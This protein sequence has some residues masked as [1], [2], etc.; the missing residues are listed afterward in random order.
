MS[1]SVVLEVLIL[2]SSATAKGGLTIE[3]PTEQE[4]IKGSPPGCWGDLA[5]YIN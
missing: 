3:G 4:V 5:I 1:T 2:P